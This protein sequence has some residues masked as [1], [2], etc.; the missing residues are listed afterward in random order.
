MNKR[1]KFISWPIRMWHIYK[2]IWN[3]I[4]DFHFLN[5]L[6]FLQ[7]FFCYFLIIKTEI[8]T[9]FLNFLKKKS[10]YSL[11]NQWQQAT[12]AQNY[13]NLL[14]GH[15]VPVTGKYKGIILNIIKENSSYLKSKLIW[16]KNRIKYSKSIQSVE[17]LSLC[18]SMGS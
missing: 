2:E 14:K 10:F 15:E 12:C 13:Y 16:K 4:I 3:F 1:N 8:S 9:L 11:C 6:S 5:F 17:I 18:C 7:I